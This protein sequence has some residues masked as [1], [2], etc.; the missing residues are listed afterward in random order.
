MADEERK[1]VRDAYDAEI[2]LHPF[3][4]LTKRVFAIVK[5]SYKI[6]GKNCEL[7][8]AE[9]LLNNI[10]DQ[11]L[12]PRLR[13][14]CDFWLMKRSADFV[15]RGSAYAREGKPVREMQAAV[16]IG[17]RL[18]RLAVFGNRRIGWNAAGRPAIAAP[19]PFEEM[20]L[21]YENAYGGIDFRVPVSD[22]DP[23]YQSAALEVDWPGLYPRNPFGKGYLVDPA[24]AEN[25]EM[26]NLEDP[27]DLLTADRLIV[28]DPERWY[29]QPLPWCFDWVHPFTWPRS[30]FFAPEYADAWFP[31]PEDERMPEVKRG[32]LAHGYRTHLQARG[33]D[34]QSLDAFFQEGSYGLVL[35]GLKGNE[36]VMIHGMHPSEP[37]LA[38]ELPGATPSIEIDIE[39]KRTRVLSR[40]HSIVC[41]PAEKRLTMVWAANCDLPRVF[42]PGIHKHIP[43]SIFVNGDAPI[44]Y[45]APPTVK[46]LVA[47]AEANREK[48]DVQSGSG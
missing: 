43:I 30:L 31:G 6:A 18:K 25:T 41:H 42:M 7:M 32:F 9:P 14:G 37:T 5:F 22:D 45:Q 34:E 39:G 3:R 27:S 8:K 36:P 20:P 38:F 13:P 10:L 2:V 35:S 11:S 40:L 16:Q 15:V 19:E 48:K 24:P 46:E 12:D 21:I 47:T 4:G 1:P 44:H 17:S 26:P 23:Q 33:E 29:L 28:N